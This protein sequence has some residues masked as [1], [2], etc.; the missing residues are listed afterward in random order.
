M[1]FREF[2][3]ADVQPNDVVRILTPNKLQIAYFAFLGATAYPVYLSLGIL[4]PSY[5]LDQSIVVPLFVL[6]A[7]DSYV[8]RY[9]YV[10]MI[11]GIKKYLWV[12]HS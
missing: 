9:T 6:N 5:G 8:E 3:L 1:G 11:R 7:L 12:R 2:M 4:G 10:I